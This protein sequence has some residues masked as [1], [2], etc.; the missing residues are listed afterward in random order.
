MV[1]VLRIAKENGSRSI[2]VENK[3]T[4]AVLHNLFRVKKYSMCDCTQH[5]KDNNPCLSIFK[6]SIVHWQLSV[7]I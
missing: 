1:E 4:N 5:I 6:Y 2:L 7:N 3:F